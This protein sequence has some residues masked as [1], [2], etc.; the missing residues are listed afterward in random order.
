MKNKV[1]YF[2]L[3]L[4]SSVVIAS[5]YNYFHEDESI[6]NK[7]YFVLNKD[8]NVGELGLLKKGTKIKFDK[9]MSEGFSRFI[10][11]L[12]IKGGDISKEN[13]TDVIIPY[14]LNEVNVNDSINSIK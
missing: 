6:K 12:N 9:G 11:Y 4:L 7:P 10:L 13:E 5:I 2:A 8:F 14:W 3:G 1:I